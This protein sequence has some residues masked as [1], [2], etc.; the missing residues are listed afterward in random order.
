M[1]QPPSASRF[2]VTSLC[3]L[4]LLLA[5]IKVGFLASLILA[6]ATP[7]S[8]DERAADMPAVAERDVSPAEKTLRAG[9]TENGEDSPRSV[10]APLAP[11]SELPAERTMTAEAS[12]VIVSPAD[13]N[14]P[15]DAASAEEHDGAA[16]SSAAPVEDALA[17]ASSR[18]A[19]GSSRLLGIS[20]A[21]AAD[22]APVPPVMPAPNARSVRPSASPHIPAAQTARPDEAVIPTPPAPNVKPYVSRDSAAQKQAELNRQEQELLALQQ[23]MEHRMTELHGL[24]G[25]IQTMLQQAT[26]TQDGKF[27]QLVDMYANMKPRQA[28]A[29]LTTVDEEVAVKIL[30]GMKSKQSGE[31]LSYMD[32]RHAARLSEVLAKMQ[33]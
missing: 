9:V 31:I 27:K 2:R 20:V 16:A 29:A 21:Y 33:M 7:F 14:L 1:K 30:T 11:D 10:S 6:P 3:R 19:L 23:Q 32:P 15:P 25:R 4:I 13:R 17:R 5:A 28:A 8:H 12:P 22:L 26:T 18:T 24:E